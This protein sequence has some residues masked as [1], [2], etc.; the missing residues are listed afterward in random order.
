MNKVTTS[1]GIAIGSIA[2]F[3]LAYLLAPTS[4]RKLEEKLKLEGLKLRRQAVL[5]ADD[6]VNSLNQTIEREVTKEEARRINDMRQRME[7]NEAY[8]NSRIVEDTAL[9]PA[10]ETYLNN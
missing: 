5:K 10:N 2:G 4:G 3:G 7:A 9:S 6:L 8:G 1:I